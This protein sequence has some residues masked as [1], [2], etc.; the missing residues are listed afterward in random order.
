[1]NINGP[2]GAKEPAVALVGAAVKKGHAVK[3]GADVEH[4]IHGTAGAVCVG[5]ATDDQDTAEKPVSYAHRP[6]ERVVACAGAA[7]AVDALLKSDGTGKLV[8]AVAG[9][10]VVA[11][12]REAAGADLDLVCVEIVGSAA[13][14]VAAAVAGVAAGYKI[15]RGVHR[16]VAAEDT[17]VTGLATVVA[18]VVS[19][20]DPPT[21]KQLFARASIGDQAGAPAAGSFLLKTFKPT[22]VN[23]VTPV[24]AT[25]FSD[26]MDLAWIAIGT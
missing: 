8:T 16:Q 20:D 21:I 26:N 14:L 6:G 11:I 5:I 15:A 10:N 18:V 2:K 25:D 4:V 13:S 7:F 3:R 17:V 1:M 24:A 12:A 23:D 19:F 9:D 22:A